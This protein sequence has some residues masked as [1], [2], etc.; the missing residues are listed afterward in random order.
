[1]TPKKDVLIL[2]GSASESSSNLKI[3]QRVAER[4]QPRF[5][6][7]IYQQLGALPPF[8]PRL[9]FDNSPELVQQL[10]H[11]I[12]QADGVI[13]CTPEYIFSIPSRLKNVLEWCVSTTVFANK[14][15]GLVTAS[16][17]GHRGHAELQ[18]IMQTLM[19]RFTEETTLL[20]SAVKGKLDGQ[21]TIT[22]EQTRTDLDRFI[23]AFDR[24]MD[25]QS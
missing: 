10:R 15:V 6:T 19:A 24:L 4:A 12:S 11:Q 20:I 23:V 18:L 25:T 8:D 3:M 7:T 21:G 1:M 16:A 9:S 22:D 13:I 2:I 5:T 17:D 14:P